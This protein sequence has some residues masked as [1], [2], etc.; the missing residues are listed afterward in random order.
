MPMKIVMEMS[1]QKIGHPRL[2]EGGAGRSAIFKI[3]DDY[4]E[5]PAAPGGK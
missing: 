2:R 3:P 4:K 1:G 5:L